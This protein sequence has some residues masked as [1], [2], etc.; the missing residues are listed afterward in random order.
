MAA[1]LQAPNLLEA[2]ES[3]D[4][5]H[6]EEKSE[7]LWLVALGAMVV[8]HLWFGL[9]STSFRLDETATWWV[10]K[11]GAAEAARRS[12]YWSGQSPLFYWTAWLSSRLF[13]LSEVSLR[14]PS[15]GAMAGAAYFL[16]RIAERFDRASAGLTALVFV[17]LASYFAIDAR[18]YALAFFFLTLSAWAFLCWLDTGRPVGAMVYVL[19]GAAVIY[20]HCLMA[21]ALGATAIYGIVALRKQPLQLTWLVGLWVS[22]GLL[23][24]PLLP[25]LQLFYGA[26][27]AHTYSVPPSLSQFTDSFL[28]GAPWSAIL[29]GIWICLL[30]YRDA[31]VVRKCAGPAALL[32]VAWSLFPQ[33]FLYLLSAAGDLQLYVPKYY[34]SALPGQALL[35][36]ILISSIRPSSIRKLIVV[37]LALTSLLIQGKGAV[38]SHG[39]EDWRSAMQFV[40]KE[41]GARVPVLIMSGFV[42]AADFAS[43]RKTALRDVLFAPQVVYGEPGRTIR[44]PNA[45]SGRDEADLEYVARQLEDE[46]R[47]F[48][49]T[50][51]GDRTYETWLL[52][53]LGSRCKSEQRGRERFAEVWLTRFTCDRQDEFS[54]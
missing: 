7:R 42:E 24:V 20:A 25:Q 41:A 40:N 46:P 16:Y 11:D 13:G 30:F 39:S 48:L 45:F 38:R 22:I 21:P 26:R 50:E 23:C 29:L 2:P 5:N 36:G 53:R 28:P 6:D 35:L 18:P 15:V 19:A 33:V 9:I 32:A 52:G 12:F 49:L 31:T 43:L 3:A 10:V 37:A 17:C 4:W 34:S 54:H 44:L 8:V 27:S 51:N 1:T 14:I 47:F